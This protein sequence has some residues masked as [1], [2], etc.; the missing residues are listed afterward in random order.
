M[1]NKKPE[2][3][4]VTYMFKGGPGTYG[5]GGKQAVADDFIEIPQNANIPTLPY[6]TS[7]S[8]YHRKRKPKFNYNNTLNILLVICVILIIALKFFLDSYFTTVHEKNFEDLISKLCFAFIASYIFYNI[9]TKTNDKLKKREA[10]AVICGLNDSIITQSSSVQKYLLK[11]AGKDDNTNLL[12][13]SKE[14]FK[15]LCS[16]VDLNAIPNGHQTNIANLIVHNGVNRIKFFADK[17]FTYMPFLESELIH[18]INQILNSKFSIFIIVIPYKQ[19]PNLKEFSLELLEFFELINQLE[20]YNNKLKKK[21]LK[22]NYEKKI[23]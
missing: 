20:S 16:E 18:Q 22:N 13:M 15:T 23:L 1:Q 14:D 9:V 10:Y 8:I 7:I 19:V 6:T 3:R 12:K 2:K 21:Y 4:K 11:G 17:I 5:K